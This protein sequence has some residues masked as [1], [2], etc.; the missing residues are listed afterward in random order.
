ML[1]IY[2]LKDSWFYQSCTF[3]SF[4]NAEIIK[5]AANHG[6]MREKLDNVDAAHEVSTVI[7]GISTAVI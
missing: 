1:L 7:Y 5:P 6:E 3:E 4:Q 2:I